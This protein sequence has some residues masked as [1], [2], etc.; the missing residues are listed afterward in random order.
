MSAQILIVGDEHIV[1]KNL[2]HKLQRLGYQVPSIV[3]SGANAIQKAKEIRLDLILM[4][5]HLQGELD[6]IHTTEYIQQDLHVPIVYMTADA[7]DATR[8]RTK[9][10]TPSGYLTKPFV[11][12]ELRATIEL[13][14]YKHQLEA[15]LRESE[16][17]YRDLLVRFHHQEKALI[18]A[19]ASFSQN[20][21]GTPQNKTDFFARM[22][23]E[24]RTPLH[25]VMGYT[26][27]LHNGAFGTVSDEQKDILKR[28]EKN[29]RTLLSFATVLL[30]MQRYQ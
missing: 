8:Q 13:A 20:Q 17:R 12:Q 21:A 4:D 26:D 11:E 22:S 27:L 7:D 23:H 9:I 25:I 5:I 29:A 24:L 15:Q 2:Q 1:A 14:I 18:L 6:G 16:A 19:N 10:P 30:D 28:I 3:T